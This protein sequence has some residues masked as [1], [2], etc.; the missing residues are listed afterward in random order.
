MSGYCDQSKWR[1]ARPVCS[2]KAAGR[3][4]GLG[5]LSLA[6]NP[7]ARGG[8]SEPCASRASAQRLQGF[9]ALPTKVSIT[10]VMWK[11]V[12]TC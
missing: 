7:G 4:E 10:A 12:F 3:R 1:A 8:G 9:P 6:S 5:R 2:I 11:A